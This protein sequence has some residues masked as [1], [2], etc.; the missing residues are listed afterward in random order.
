[1]VAAR[2][3]DDQCRKRKKEIHFNITIKKEIFYEN[4]AGE[5][6]HK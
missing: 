4:I 3:G 2:Q 6:R 1:M 5:N